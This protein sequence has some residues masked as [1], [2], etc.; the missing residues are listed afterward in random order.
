MGKVTIPLE[1]FPH[2]TIK[3]L[4]VGT[5]KGKIMENKYLIKPKNGLREDTKLAVEYSEEEIKNFLAN[6]Y[7]IVNESDFN[8]LI[9]NADD[10]YLIADDGTIYVKPDPSDAELLAKAKTTKLAQID[11]LTAAK[12]IGGF[13]STCT[14]TAVTYDSD[15]DTQL[16]MQGI[17]LNVNSD[18]FAEKYSNGCPVRGYVG[19]DTTK[20]VLWLTPAQVLAW[21]ADLSIHI[22]TCK[23][24]GWQKQAEVAA[25]TTVAE[26]EAIEI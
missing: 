5:Q 3:P 6:G 17:A 12:I 9:G 20:S 11:T 2:C 15:K 25:A 1:A 21:Q 24:W 14:G 18:T 23:Q 19:D 4:A 13:T 7:Y 8:K 22:G 26:V 16:T 10:E